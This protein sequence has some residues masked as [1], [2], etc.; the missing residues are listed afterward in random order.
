MTSLLKAYTYWKHNRGKIVPFNDGFELNETESD[1]EEIE[2]EKIMCE[3]T[4]GAGKVSQFH[5]IS[6]LV[7]RLITGESSCIITITVYQPLL[8]D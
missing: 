5:D 7:E 2:D 6:N 4:K 3:N 1:S 8:S